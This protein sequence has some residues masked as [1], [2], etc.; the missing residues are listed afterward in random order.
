[1]SKVYAPHAPSQS[2]LA[3]AAPAAALRCARASIS[4]ASSH[5]TPS[6]R[7]PI[8]ALAAS[9]P[10]PPSPPASAASATAR[11]SAAAAAASRPSFCNTPPSL[12]ELR[13]A[14][15]VRQRLL[16]PIH[17]EQGGAAV[18][19][20]LGH[21]AVRQCLALGEREGLAVEAASR[22]RVARTH[23]AVAALPLLVDGTLDLQLR[24]APRM[25]LAHHGGL[26]VDAGAIHHRPLREL[27]L[28]YLVELCLRTLL[29]CE[30]RLRRL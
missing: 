4:A 9:P 2:P 5:A 20:E 25:L 14:S 24:L 11:R 18:G 16:R 21:L 19:V 12:G 1:M 29:A 22:D 27:E 28:V 13:R 26:E 7:A 23:R 15:R 30:G 8:S 6:R 17:G 3:A 10:S